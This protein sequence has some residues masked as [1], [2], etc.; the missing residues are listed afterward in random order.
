MP[1]VYPLTLKVLGIDIPFSVTIEPEDIEP[2]EKDIDRFMVVF[3]TNEE[4][5]W[6]FSLPEEIITDYKIGISPGGNPL[7]GILK[8]VDNN[9]TI[10][11]L[12]DPEL[13]LG[14]YRITLLLTDQSGEQTTKEVTLNIMK[15]IN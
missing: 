11:D 2:T 7:S 15:P 9:L 10:D 5:T 8:L 4:S 13:E 14:A 3:K 1:G 6:Q 12:S